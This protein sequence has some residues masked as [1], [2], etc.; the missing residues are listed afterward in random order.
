MRNFVKLGMTA[1]AAMVVLGAMAVPAS[2]GGL[3]ITLTCG[4]TTLT[5]VVNGNGDW[6]PARDSGSTRVFHPT[7][8]G[9]F[10]GTF[11]PADPSQ[12][13]TNET[14]APFARKNQPRNGR[15]TVDCTYH[16]TFT[17]PSGTFAGGGGV[18]GWTSGTRNN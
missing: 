16:F 2:A 17:D 10:T 5:A 9:E 12:P 1:A 14:E 8:F 15:P 18:T 3:P 4:G 11:T 13:P 6:A 7:A